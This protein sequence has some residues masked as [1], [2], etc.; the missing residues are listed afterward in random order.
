MRAA[1]P[2]PFSTTLSIISVSWSAMSPE[3]GSRHSSGWV[4]SMTVRSGAVTWST[5]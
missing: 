3:M 1:R 2:E 5:R 4:E